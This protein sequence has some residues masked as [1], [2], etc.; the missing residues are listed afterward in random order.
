MRTPRYRQIAKTALPEDESSFK[1]TVVSTLNNPGVRFNVPVPSIRTYRG[2]SSERKSFYR[3]CCWRHQ[4]PLGQNIADK[5][6]NP[7]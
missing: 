7:M 3:Q 2:N 4:E 5:R 6:M 1:G